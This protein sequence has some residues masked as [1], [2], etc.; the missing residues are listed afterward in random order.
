LGWLAR[1]QFID[2]VIVALPN[3][4]ALVRE[5]AGILSDHLDIKVVPRPAARAVATNWLERIG[6]SVI[7]CIASRCPSAGLLLSGSW[8]WWRRSGT[9]PYPPAM[10]LLRFLIRLDSHGPVFYRGPRSGTKG[11]AFRCYKFRP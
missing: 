3:E 10:V 4:P 11:R 9:R 5:A 2:E 6:A 7:P 8:I 1:R